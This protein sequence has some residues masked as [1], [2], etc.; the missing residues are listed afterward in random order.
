MHGRFGAGG[1]EQV[2]DLADALNLLR[3]LDEC[4]DQILRRQLATQLH[5]AL[6]SVDVDRAFENSTPNYNFAALSSSRVYPQASPS[7]P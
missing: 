4:V 3:A 6:L 5:H 7:P 2:L 1:V